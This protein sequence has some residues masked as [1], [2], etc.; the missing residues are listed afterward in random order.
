M[1][2]NDFS[3][4]MNK[5]KNVVL[6]EPTTQSKIDFANAMLT[7]NNIQKIPS[8][9]SDF[10]KVHNGLIIPPF[11]LYGTDVIHRNN[12]NYKFPNLFDINSLFIK[13]KN[14]LIENRIVVGSIGFDIILYDYIDSKYKIV[15][16]LNFEIIEQFDTS[17]NLFDYVINTL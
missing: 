1:Q 6:F 9:Y 16:R 3:S 10:L 8:D 13:N 4:L 14:P 15:N 17:D 2:K 7:N 5:F 12:Y 11:E